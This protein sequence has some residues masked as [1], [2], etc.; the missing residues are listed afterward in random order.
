MVKA[1][2]GARTRHAVSRRAGS[3]LDDYGRPARADPGHRCRVGRA[4][5]GKRNIGARRGDCCLGRNGAASLSVMARSVAGLRVDE[6]RLAE[7]CDRYG[8]A[9]LEVFGSS[10]RGEAGPGSDIDIL[11]TVRPGR[12]LGWEIV[13]LADELSGL[14][15]RPVDLVSRRAL[16]PLLRRAVLAEARMLYAA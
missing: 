16:Q 11:Y 12:R 10:A 8:I 1:R 4:P 13:D 6:H 14:L 3:T 7:I 15:G 5:L 2:M 9:E